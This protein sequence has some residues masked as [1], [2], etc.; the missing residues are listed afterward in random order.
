M[1]TTC[2][3]IK[4]VYAGGIASFSFAH[5]TCLL[6][7]MACNPSSSDLAVTPPQ[8]ILPVFLSNPLTWS[9]ML[10]YT[11]TGLPCFAW[12]HFRGG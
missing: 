7:P 3:P 12:L 10:P 2:S 11:P 8:D 6:N 9:F 4:W 5:G 1:A